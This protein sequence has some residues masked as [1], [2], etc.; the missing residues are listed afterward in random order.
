MTIQL[1]LYPPVT[2]STSA[3]KERTEEG[4]NIRMVSTQDSDLICIRFKVPI[5]HK[6]RGG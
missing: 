6:S 5:S 3:N 4:A 1:Y 2:I